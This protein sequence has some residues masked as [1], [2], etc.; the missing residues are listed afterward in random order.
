M[1]NSTQKLV[2]TSE[3]DTAANARHWVTQHARHAG[4]DE[5]QLF[6]IELAVGEALTNVV[7]HAYDGEAGH[8]IHLSLTIDEAKLALTIRDFGR[9]F[10]KELYTP[11]NLN[12][13]SEHGGYGVF[14][15]SE[16]M[17]EV[18]YDTSLPQGTQ[19][20]MVKYKIGDKR[21]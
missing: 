7:E 5:S 6:S 21:G 16:L 8:Q 19:M 10:K 20:K 1:K 13:P 4:F 11:P 3:L 18:F 12:I 2:I 15:I 14:L 9:K 17:D